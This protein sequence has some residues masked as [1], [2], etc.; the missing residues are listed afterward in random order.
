MLRVMVMVMAMVMVMVMLVIGLRIMLRMRGPQ[1]PLCL[2]HWSLFGSFVQLNLTCNQM[3]NTKH[4]K[5][6]I[7]NTK[8]TKK[9]KLKFL[10]E[11]DN[12]QT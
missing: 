7:L 4:S 1:N 12:P 2:S 3:L 10:L 11:T 5:Y 8:N 9:V 6:L